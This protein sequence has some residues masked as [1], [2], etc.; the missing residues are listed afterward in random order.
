MAGPFVVVKT[1]VSFIDKIRI[2]MQR[3]DQSVRIDQMHF[4]CGLPKLMTM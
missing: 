2:E 4:L 1:H 3:S